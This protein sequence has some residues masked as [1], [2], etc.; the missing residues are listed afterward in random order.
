MAIHLW[1]DGKIFYKFDQ[2]EKRLQRLCK[3]NIIKAFNHFQKEIGLQFIEATELDQDFIYITKSGK[4]KQGDE[5]FPVSNASSNSSEVGKRAA[6]GKQFLF[7][8]PSD[9]SEEFVAVHEIGHSLGLIHTHQRHDR[10]LFIKINFH[11]LNNNVGVSNF[12]IRKNYQDL[13]SPYLCSDLNQE[14][15]V[16][17]WNDFSYDFDSIMQYDSYTFSKNLDSPVI[18]KIKGGTIEGQNKKLSKKDKLF[19]KSIYHLN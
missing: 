3:K 5:I 8:N 2:S 6:G 10:D 4:T 14:D 16:L 9:C 11:H 1:P 17:K 13:Y 18:V 12:T 7:F 19:L 15:C